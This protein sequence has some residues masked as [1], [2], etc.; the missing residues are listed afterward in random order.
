MIGGGEEGRHGVRTYQTCQLG[1][2][3]RRRVWLRTATATA[4]ARK[5]RRVW[6]LTNKESIICFGARPDT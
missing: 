2:N 4:R 3:A 6:K 5:L 1:D